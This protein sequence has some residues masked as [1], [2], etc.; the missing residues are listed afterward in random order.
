MEII[1]ETRL[2]RVRGLQRAGHQAFLGIRY[3]EAP[4]GGLRFRPPRRIDA[5]D[6]TYNATRH[7]PI[8]PQGYPDQPPIRLE[9]AEDCLF[10]N[11]Y[12]PAADGK[13]RPVMVF[14]HGG[15]F[16]IDSGSRP[17]TDGGML[18]ARGNVVVVTVEYRLGALGFLCAAGVEPNLGLQDQVCA[19]QWVQRNIADFGGDPAN[20]TVFGESAGATSVAYLLVMP[21]ARGLF[22]RAIL[23]SGAFPLES[24]AENR[25]LAEKCSRKF[26]KELGVGPGD[27]AALQQAPCSDIMRA[28]RKVAGRLVL[29]DR[30]FYPVRDGTVVPE[31]VYGALRKG[32]AAGIPLI[33]GINGEELPLFGALVKPGLQQLLLRR[34]ITRWLGKWGVGRKDTRALLDLYRE[35]L[36]PEERAAHR[37]YNHLL[38]DVYFRVPAILLAE[39]HLAAAGRVYFYCFAHRAPKVGAAMHVMELYFVFGTLGT[40]DVA[41]VM[42][43]PGSEEEVR[44]SQA[45][46][47]AWATFARTG[48][49]DHAGLPTWPPYDLER[50]ATMILGLS[51]HVAN[52]PLEPVRLRWMEA[53][54][55]LI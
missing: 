41:E 33:V 15:G 1:V 46:M 47:D 28:Q 32:S 48:C 49:P 7:G 20:V 27:L 51:P 35:A 52:A 53:V 55:S 31:D 16:I 45:M 50:R 43:V 24:V 14:I 19:L 11:I 42:R 6:G 10:L 44:L 23:E 8:A 3:A 13:A 17:R 12:T 22:H 54:R 2:G 5:W 40:S 21:V 36:T 39:A 37:E 4:V 29:G 38:S 26:L 34:V 18:A 30:A 9:E 25:R